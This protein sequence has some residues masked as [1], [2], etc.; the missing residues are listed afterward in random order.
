MRNYTAVTA[1][2][3]AD[4][5]ITLGAFDDSDGQGLSLRTDT[6]SSTST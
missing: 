4:L 5:L 3:K 2:Q 6:P 1:M